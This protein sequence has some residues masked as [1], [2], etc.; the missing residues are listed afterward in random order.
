M[1]QPITRRRGGPLG[2][3]FF[4]DLIH[5]EKQ[6]G[7]K[8]AI[9]L[10]S[11]VFL[12]FLGIMQRENL[13]LEETVF[14][15]AYFIAG[16]IF[17]RALLCRR[18]SVGLYLPKKAGLLQDSLSRIPCHE[19]T[20]TVFHHQKNPHRGGVYT[21]RRLQ[22]ELPDGC[23]CDGVYKQRQQG[24]I[25]GVHIVQYL[26]ACVSGGCHPVK[27]SSPLPY[28]RLWDAATD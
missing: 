2:V 19:D 10:M 22:Q 16:G 14:Y 24:E 3:R 8:I 18:L 1:T 4:R 27:R 26:R 11:P 9:L 21:V 25:D 20:R 5:R 28:R 17:T 12:L 6:T 15:L 7:R 13:Q 23:G